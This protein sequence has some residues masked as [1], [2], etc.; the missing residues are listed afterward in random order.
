MHRYMTCLRRTDMENANCRDLSKAY[1]KCRMDNGLM[2]KEEWKALGYED[3]AQRTPPTKNLDNSST[4]K[5]S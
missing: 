5:K 3:G 1:L 4:A 2:A